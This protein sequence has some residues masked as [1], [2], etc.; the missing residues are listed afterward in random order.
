MLFWIE[1]ENEPNGEGNGWDYCQEEHAT[2]WVIYKGDTLAD[3]HAE[4]MDAYDSRAEAEA[5]LLIYEF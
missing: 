5:M 3:P 1:T 4:Q 2:A